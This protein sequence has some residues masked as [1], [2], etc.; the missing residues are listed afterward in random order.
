MLNTIIQNPSKNHHFTIGDSIKIFISEDY[1]SYGKIIKT[2]G[3]KPYTNFKISWYYRPN[4]I[5]EN[6]PKFFSSA[7]LLI[8]DHIQDISIENID[9]K[10]EVLT[11]KE[12]HSRSQVNEDVFFTRGWYCPIEN[13][14]KPTLSHWER[15]CLCE[16][17]LNPDEIYVTCEKCENMFHFECVEG[18]FEIYWTCDSCSLGKM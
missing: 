4:D 9:G 13:V 8:S 3:R 15:V 5:F 16:S 6:V 18:G 12:Y 17:I 2:Y 11:L 1:D 7:E 10:I 14:L